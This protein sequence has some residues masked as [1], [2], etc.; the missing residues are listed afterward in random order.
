MV[1]PQKTR[2]TDFRAI[3]VQLKLKSFHYWYGVHKTTQN[4][5]SFPNN[6][7]QFYFSTLICRRFTKGFQF[8]PLKK[9]RFKKSREIIFA[10]IANRD[11]DNIAAISSARAVARKIWI[12]LIARHVKS[13]DGLSNSI[14][15]R[16]RVR[17]SYVT[18]TMIRDRLLLSTF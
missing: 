15:K 6:Y 8:K 18:P 7:C 9:P 12:C 1:T 4:Q 13:Y 11:L 17:N 5:T 10:V 3:F 14:G 2:T 16:S